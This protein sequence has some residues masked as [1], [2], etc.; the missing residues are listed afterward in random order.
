MYIKETT[1]IYKLY[2]VQA[3][4]RLLSRV[5][6]WR[7]TTCIVCLTKPVARPGHGRRHELW[8]RSINCRRLASDPPHAAQLTVYA[9]ARVGTPSGMA[10]G[11][12]GRRTN[13][14]NWPLANP[15]PTITDL[16]DDP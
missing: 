11:M 12:C 3:R 4:E 13:A 8:S 5:G 1:Y 6:A 10:T 15:S 2:I 9:H 16:D 7:G 14:I